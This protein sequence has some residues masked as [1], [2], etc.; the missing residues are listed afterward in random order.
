MRE[1]LALVLR[2]LIEP[3][4]AEAADGDGDRLIDGME[5]RR[6]RTGISVFEFERSNVDRI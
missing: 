6:I 3:P 5:V 2:L 1:G 4:V